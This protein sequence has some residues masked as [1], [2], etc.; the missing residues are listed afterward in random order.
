MKETKNMLRYLFVDLVNQMSMLE[1]NQLR[2]RGIH[3]LTIR[4]IH[5]IEAIG[6]NENQQMN[7]VAQRLQISMGTL[8]VVIK[9]L[10]DKNY[11]TRKRD[12]H[13]RRI[14]RLNLTQAGNEVNEIHQRF[15]TEMIDELVSDF[16][17]DDSQQIH[18]FLNELV[19]Y[20]E[21]YSTHGKVVKYE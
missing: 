4:E 17:R 6:M 11:V 16:V 21:K 13:D 19:D 10:V 3:D 7:V 18:E 15:H 8:T 5:V 1:E 20:F 2:G 9:R 14:F 12:L